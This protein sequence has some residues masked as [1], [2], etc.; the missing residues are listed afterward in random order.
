MIDIAR[1]I[2]CGVLPTQAR[3]FAE[4]LRAACE[5]FEIA[6]GN[7]LAA[8]IAQA[9][10]E[11]SGFAR[12]EESLYY[13]TPQ[14]LRAVWPTRF[15]SDA[16][17]AGYTRNPKRLANYVYANRMGNSGPDDG[18]NY[19]GRG[20]FQLTG[21]ANYTDAAHQLQR[22]YVAQPELVCAPPD[23]ALT[24]AWFWRRVGCSTALMLHGIDGT[25]RKINGGMHGAAERRELFATCRRVLA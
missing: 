15:T 24:A 21:R 23:A 14:R 5:R 8:F 11:S 10:H 7:E 12:L 13:S 6:P 17:A 3:L 1:L 22:D 4:P 20:L 16:M 19:R 2:A 18:W 25:T 9:M